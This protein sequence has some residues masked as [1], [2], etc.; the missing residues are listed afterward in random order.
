MS[1]RTDDGTTTTPESPPALQLID[2][3]AVTAL[4][5]RELAPGVTY[6]PLWT[7]GRSFAGVFHLE[8]DAVIPEH[9]HTSHC[10][11]V[12]MLDGEVRI[13]DR[14]LPPGSYAYVAPGQPHDLVAGPDGATAFYLYLVTSTP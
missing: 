6:A 9:T 11:H 3:G 2:A 12:W 13:L 14:T 1:T 5:R 10:H 7:E 8:P 4:P